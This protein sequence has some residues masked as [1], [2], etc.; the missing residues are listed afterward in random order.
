VRGGHQ[1]RV[2]RETLDDHSG[3][4]DR[5]ADNYHTYSC[6]ARGAEFLL[7]FHPLLDRHRWAA[8]KTT[9]PTATAPAA[10]ATRASGSAVTTST[11][12]EGM[13][14]I[15]R[16]HYPTCSRSAGSAGWLVGVERGR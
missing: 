16:L 4:V 9:D 3:A 11:N 14:Q 8:T 1:D 12:E 10:D 2:R 15:A 6:Y 13:S 5:L 7:G